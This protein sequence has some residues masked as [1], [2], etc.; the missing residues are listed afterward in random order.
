GGGAVAGGGDGE[1]GARL[2]GALG[3]ARCELVL[4]DVTDPGTAA[5][6]VAAAAR[7]G[8]LDVLVNNAAVDFSSDLYETSAEDVRRVFEVNVVGAF[9]MLQAAARAMR[10]RGG[11]VINGS[12]RTAALR[13]P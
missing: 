1:A 3:E 7:L 8:P 6:A 11:A 5:A 9:L 2:L 4:G 13:R 12:S 10:G